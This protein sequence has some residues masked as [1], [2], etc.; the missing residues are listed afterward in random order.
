MRSNTA[1][2]LREGWRYSQ[3]KVFTWT[4]E[5]DKFPKASKAAV[6]KSPGHPTPARKTKL[7]K[8]R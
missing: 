5:V 7:M 6:S 3:R 1:K 8:S 2:K 4:P